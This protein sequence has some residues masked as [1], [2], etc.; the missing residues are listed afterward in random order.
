[1]AVVQIS[2]IQLRR[3]R[4]NTGTGLPQLA[5]GELGW[6]VDNKELWIGNG[7]IA[8]GAPAVGNTRILTEAD[9]LSSS[10]STTILDSINYTY[11]FND[12]TITTG[13]NSGAP[14]VRTLQDRLDDYVDIFNFGVVND[15]VTDTTVTLQHAINQLFLNDFVTA[16]HDPSRRVDLVLPPGV[17]HITST[18]YIPSYASLIG[19]GSEKTIINY[20]GT[21]T[22]MQV[23]NEA[24]FSGGPSSIVHTTGANQPKNISIKGMTISVN[25]SGIDQ[26]QWYHLNTYIVNDIVSYNGLRY[27]AILTNVNQ[28]PISTSLYWKIVLQSGLHL[29]AVKDSVFEDLTINGNW[30]FN[31]NPNQIAIKLSAVSDVVTCYHNQFNNISIINFYYGVVATQDTMFNVF[32]ECY[33]SNVKEG[34]MLGHGADGSTVGMLYGP[35][36]TAIIN[37][38]FNDVKNHAVYI[39]YGTA[40]TIE[41][42]SL[43]NVGNNG[44]VITDI[45]YPQIFIAVDGNTVKSTNSDRSLPLGAASSIT[46]SVTLTLG[47]NIIAAKNSLVV[48]VTSGAQGFLIADVTNSNI[49]TLINLNSTVFD[50]VNLLEIAGSFTPSTTNTAVYPTIV[51]IVATTTYIPYIPE[52]SGRGSFASYSSRQLT[53]QVESIP[54]IAFRLPFWVDKNGV[55]GESIFYEINYIYR[56]VLSFTRYGTLYIA[57]DAANIVTDLKDEYDILGTGVTLLSTELDFN[58]TILNQHGTLYVSGGTDVPS[59]IAISYVNTLT[60]DINGEFS[61]SYT[62]TF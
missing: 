57:A 30:D 5:S 10:G 19:A 51:G 29:D 52:V 34:F 2:R 16:A 49:I 31:D 8:E 43:V 3:G 46:S 54:T 62:A 23:V 38:Q 9:L 22:A 21:G 47:A 1:M 56:S 15:G 11:K 50:T 36:N 61:Y 14:V 25:N 6:A 41:N 40:N 32:N 20:V 18:L 55:V 12:V 48:Q 27:I 4:G 59:T 7:S 37:C 53:L 26:G 13:P 35:R 39:E 42:C 44:G 58:A 24:S 60:G 45:V 28:P 17:Y 33:M